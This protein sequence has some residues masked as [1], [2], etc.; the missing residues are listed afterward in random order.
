MIAAFGN[1]GL[2]EKA[3]EIFE[4]MKATRVKPDS[5]TFIG[6]SMLVTSWLVRKGEFYFNSMKEA[7]WIAPQCRTFFMSY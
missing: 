5:V 3:I 1:H 6:L 4:K 7:Y 2:G